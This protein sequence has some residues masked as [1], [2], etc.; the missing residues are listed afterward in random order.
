MEK[1]DGLQKVTELLSS[2]CMCK[3]YDRKMVRPEKNLMRHEYF[4][5]HPDVEE[6]HPST[7]SV[8]NLSSDTAP[9]WCPFRVISNQNN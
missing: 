4:C 9:V 8:G 2:C 3:Y 1:I 5:K 6:Q 7:D